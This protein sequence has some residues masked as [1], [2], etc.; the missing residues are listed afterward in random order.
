MHILDNIKL[1]PSRG[2]SKYPPFAKNHKPF[3]QNG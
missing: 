2:L 3:C 1:K